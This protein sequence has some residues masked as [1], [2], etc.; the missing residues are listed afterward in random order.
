MLAGA[1]GRVPRRRRESL[2]RVV[3]WR[4]PRRGGHLH[5]DLIAWTV[6]EL[7][8]L[9]LTGLGA[10]TSFAA[11]AGA[12]QRR[13][14]RPRCWPR[15]LPEPV[16]HVLIQA[17][18]TAVAPGPLVA[19]VAEAIGSVAQ[20]E[21]TGGATVFRF[22]EASIQRAFDA[23]RG[24]DDVH[25]LLERVSRTPVPQPLTY[26]VDEVARRHGRVRV[27]AVASVIRLD[28]PATGDVL[29]GDAHARR[30]RPA[31]AS[32]RRSSASKRSTQSVVEA[33]RDAGHAA[34]AEGL[35]GELLVREPSNQRAPAY[36]TARR[37]G[38]PPASPAAL[39]A[40]VRSLRAGERARASRPGQGDPSRPA[41]QPRTAVETVALLTETAANAQTVWIG[42]VDN[43]GGASERLVDPLRVQGGLA[44][45]VRP[46][47][48]RRPY[49]RRP[50]HHRRRP[51]GAGPTVPGSPAP[52]DGE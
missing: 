6:R 16:D 15:G 38:G 48:R 27:S 4:A 36:R 42:Y 28:D 49:V 32:R 12:R 39:D 23:G 1:A 47:P 34:V 26:L 7:P 29:M 10:L 20:V 45:R 21:S 41:L 25:R 8:A 43:N 22:T 46:R 2:H 5:D 31:P 11:G 35:D 14:T 44:H 50:P 3:D 52:P 30:A 17:D 51:A 13:S 40:L 33:L 9:G 24:A 19:P 18:L 37:L